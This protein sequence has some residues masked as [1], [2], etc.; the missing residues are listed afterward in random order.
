[1]ATKSKRENENRAAAARDEED[2]DYTERDRDGEN[3]VRVQSALDITEAHRG[4]LE[5]D[6]GLLTCFDMHSNSNDDDINKSEDRLK[7]H[8]RNC[9]QRLVAELFNL[10]SESDTNGRFALLPPNLGKFPRAMRMPDM[11]KEK[12]KWE[13]FAEEKGIK[14]RKRSKMVYDEQQDEWKRRYG[15]DR[16]NDSTKIAIVEAKL[17]SKPGQT[18]DP[19]LRERK[20]KKQRVEKNE[21]QRQKNLN[22]G[23]QQK[24]LPATLQLAIGLNNKSKD[25]VGASQLN[26]KLKVKQVQY[27]VSRST[28]SAG[29]FNAPIAGDEKIKARGKRRTFA[30]NTGKS[31]SKKNE[32]AFVDKLVKREK[33]KL[34]D[35]IDTSLAARKMQGEQEGKIREG[36]KK[37]LKR[38]DSSSSSKNKN[39]SGVGKKKK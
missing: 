5:F 20:D 21:L 37:D 27:K 32:L 19:F 2:G 35:G 29:K 39:S 28:A 17:S 12:T 18:E 16:A 14:K 8:S 15:Y 9:L 6:C 25:K 1:M 13:L 38:K 31:D 10:P 3:R 33:L 24:H 4:E 36:K 30:S 22:K 11:E 23:G 34:S 26:S 7:E